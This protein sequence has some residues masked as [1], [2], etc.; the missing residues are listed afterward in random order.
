MTCD[1]LVGGIAVTVLAPTLSERVLLVPFEHL[2]TPDVSQITPTGSL[3]G[4]GQFAPA[5]LN[6]KT[7]ELSLDA[8]IG[9]FVVDLACRAKLERTAK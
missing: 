1:K 5:G 6:W 3:S 2:E 4:E 7:S 8:H 9:S